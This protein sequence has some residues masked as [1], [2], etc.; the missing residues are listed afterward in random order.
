VRR[1]SGSPQLSS[2]SESAR[3]LAPFEPRAH[4]HY[5]ISLAPFSARSGGGGQIVAWKSAADDRSIERKQKST[6]LNFVNALLLCLS[7]L[8]N[9]AL[10][11]RFQC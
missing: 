6:P 7:N 9:K 2:D 8:S 10:S 1:P 5:Y 11:N 3:R 4:G